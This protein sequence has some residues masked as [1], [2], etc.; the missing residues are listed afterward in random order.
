MVRSYQIPFRSAQVRSGS[1]GSV[2][3]ITVSVLNAAMLCIAKTAEEF[4]MPP[5]NSARTHYACAIHENFLA[6]FP[7]TERLVPGNFE[8]NLTLVCLKCQSRNNN[9]KCT[10]SVSIIAHKNCIYLRAQGLSQF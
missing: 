9:S 8:V 5:H 4:R 6:N 7:F 1:S 3:R 10:A 2:V